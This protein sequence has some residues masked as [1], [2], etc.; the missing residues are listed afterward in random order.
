MVSQSA[1]FSATHTWW[2]P[3]LG[4]SHGLKPLS[5]IPAGRIPVGERRRE[6][7]GLGTKEKGSLQ[8]LKEARAKKQVS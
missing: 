3:S 1:G 6:G 7:E 8:S 2:S 5:R 4:V